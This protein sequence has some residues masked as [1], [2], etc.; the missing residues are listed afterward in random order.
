MCRPS[1]DQSGK[2][3]DLSPAP[4]RQRIRPRASATKM[5]LRSGPVTVSREKA[6]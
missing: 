3:F 1:G 5:L 4:N 2:P 6:T